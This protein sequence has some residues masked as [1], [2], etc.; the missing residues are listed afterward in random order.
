MKMSVGLGFVVCVTSGIAAAYADG[1]STQAVQFNRDVRPI[2]SSACF[3]C[4]GPDNGNRKAELRLDTE[5]GLKI[6][7]DAGILPSSPGETGDLLDRITSDD[8]KLQ[9]PPPASGHK[10]TRKQI[11]VL[12]RWVSQG[13]PWQT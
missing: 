11:A 9:M 2:L 12:R 1:A 13:A 10:L 8:P 4:H 3:A 6:S 5:A 7:R